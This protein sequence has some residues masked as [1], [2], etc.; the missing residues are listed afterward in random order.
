MPWHRE[1]MK[2][3]ITCDM[4]RLAGNKLRSGDFRMGQPIPSHVGIP[5]RGT[6]EGSETSQYLEE[7]KAN[8]ILLVAASETGTAQ[9]SI[10]YIGGL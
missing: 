9:T 5:E 6:T 4:L 2:D 8:A 10:Y 3:V 1:A 7:K